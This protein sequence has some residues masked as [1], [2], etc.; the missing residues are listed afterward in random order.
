ML[1]YLYKQN[2]AAST[3]YDLMTDADTGESQL[4]F[5][6]RPS[7]VTLA[8]EASA[9]GCEIEI[10]SGARTIVARSTLSSG[11]TDGVFPNLNE[12]TIGWFAAAGEKQRIVIREVAAA[13]S[14]DIMAVMDVQPVA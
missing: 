7:R 4:R 5:V 12:K 8:I 3:T 14:Q 13:G 1:E 9:V 2:I 11:G 6:G 10:Y